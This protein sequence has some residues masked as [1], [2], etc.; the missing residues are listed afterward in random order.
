MDKLNIR[1]SEPKQEEIPEAKLDAIIAAMAQAPICCRCGAQLQG[2]PRGQIIQ[3][4]RC[5]SQMQ[6]VGGIWLQYVSP[7]EIPKQAIDFSK[8]KLPGMH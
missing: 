3:C 4:P 1:T 7:L 2:V 5:R 8:I 6:H